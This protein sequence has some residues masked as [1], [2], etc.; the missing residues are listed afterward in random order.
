MRKL[1]ESTFVSGWRHQFSP[2]KWGSPY[3]DDA[4]D[5]YAHDLLWASDALSCWGARL[6][7][8]SRRL[9]NHDR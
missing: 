1:V 8:G 4:H 7:K 9:G 5:K 3:W 2:E 6:T